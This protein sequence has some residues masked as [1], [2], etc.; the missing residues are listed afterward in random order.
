M[1]GSLQL[2]QRNSMV[3]L[4]GKDIYRTS[5]KQPTPNPWKP[6]AYVLWKSTGLWLVTVQIR[7]KKHIELVAEM[8]SDCN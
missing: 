3:L 5:C 2:E 1:A 8:V 7:R 4:L 6:M